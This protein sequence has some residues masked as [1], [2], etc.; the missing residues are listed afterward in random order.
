MLAFGR[1]MC[2]QPFASSNESNFLLFD[3]ACLVR[4][5]MLW[6]TADSSNEF[7]VDQ[8]KV[9]SL[10]VG[11]RKL[12]ARSRTYEHCMIVIR[13]R[14]LRP[15]FS[16]RVHIHNLPWFKKSFESSR[17]LNPSWHIRI[18]PSMN[19]GLRWTWICIVWM[20]SRSRLTRYWVYTSSTS[21]FW[22]CEIAKWN[23]QLSHLPA[24]QHEW[25]AVSL[26]PR[27]KHWDYHRIGRRNHR[28]FAMEEDI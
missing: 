17:K 3:L 12:K 14:R 28:R 15:L 20:Y 6:M 1:Q 11:K 25:L 8:R 10:F 4:D 27:H 23:C 2:W 5:S 16:T 18:S 21:Q 24:P 7:H 13:A 9:R 19:E 22:S 26:L